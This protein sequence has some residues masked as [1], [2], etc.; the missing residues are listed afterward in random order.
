MSGIDIR[1]RT[2]HQHTVDPVRII[3]PGEGI[4]QDGQ[5][6]RHAS[7]SAGDGSQIFLAGDVEKMLSDPARIGNNRD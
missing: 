3:R 4:G 7:G 2:G 5:D 6:H 1:Q